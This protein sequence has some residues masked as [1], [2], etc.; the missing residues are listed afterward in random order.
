MSIYAPSHPLY[1]RPMKITESAADALISAMDTIRGGNVGTRVAVVDGPHMFELSKEGCGRG[2]MVRFT[3][4]ISE[5]TERYTALDL[6][7][8]SMMYL[9]HVE[10]RDA[11]YPDRLYVHCC[12]CIVD[13]AVAEPPKKRVGCSTNYPEMTS[14]GL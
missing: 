1:M 11:P 2:S 14:L 7:G 5:P 12:G 4:T 13:F 3:M 6:R 9:T 10:P 8:V